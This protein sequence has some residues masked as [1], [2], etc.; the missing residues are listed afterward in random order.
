MG[1][2]ADPV[3]L[4]RG[5]PDH[6][7]QRPRY[8]V[9]RELIS[10]TN[11]IFLGGGG[12]DHIEGRGGNDHI[13]GGEGNDYLDGGA[14][15][16][17]IFGGN[18]NDT[19]TFALGPG[20][21]YGYGDDF[22]DGGAGNDFISNLYGVTGESTYATAGNRVRLDGGPGFDTVSADAGL[23]TAPVLIEEGKPI[24][25]NLL[26]G[27]YITNFERVHEI[28]TNDFDD[29]FL[30]K[31]RYNNRISTR[32]GN[33]IVNPGLGIDIVW[34]GQAPGNTD[35]DL[36]ILDYSKGDDPDLTGSIPEG[37]G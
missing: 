28:I 5:L 13:D 27:G 18:G 22:A 21:D 16:D 32:G 37:G 19:I 31:G 10:S 36:L 20:W 6:R 11:D 23:A 2:S 17:T 15:S 29:V 3:F 35:D 4:H 1:N 12:N 34:F 8:H 9:W 25:I 30:L 7:R 26:N 24:H 14:G 33:D